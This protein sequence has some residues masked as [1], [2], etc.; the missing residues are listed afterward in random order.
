MEVIVKR[1]SR[2]KVSWF[3]RLF[4][5]SLLL[6]VL[7]MLAAVLLL[8]YLKMEGAPV[9]QVSQTTRLLDANDVIIGE[10]HQGQNRYWVPLE[11]ISEQLLNATLSIEDRKF[12]DHY[13][14]DPT[15]IAGAVVANVK[16]GGKAQ[17]AS[18]ITQQY[19]RNLY[20][21]HDKTWKRKFN[22][23]L[24]ALRLEMYYTKDEI[25]EGYLN[26]IYY[27]HGAYGIEAAARHFFNKK[28]SDLN[29]AEA[30]LLAGI[31]KGP[32]YYSP[33]NDFERAK[34]RQELILRSMVQTGH[35]TSAE[36]EAA[37]NKP[38]ELAISEKEDTGAIGPYFQEYVR[39]L[40]IEEYN[41]DEAL[42]EQGGLQIFTTLDRDM[43]AEAE[44]WVEIE[45]GP[46]EELQA[47]LV[48][49]DPRTGDV[50]AL[51]GGRNYLQSPFNRATQARRSPGSTFKPFLYY[52]ALEHGFTPSSTLLS[53]ATTF[54]FDDGRPDYSPSNFNNNYANDFVTLLQALAFSDNIFAVKTHLFL[55]T[56]TL[57]E[58][59]ARFGINSRLENIPSLALGSNDVQLLE[60]TNS[61]SSFTNGGKR[62]E[63]RFIRKVIDKTGQVIFE[64]EPVTEQILD[65]KLA[66]IMT[67]IMTAMFD[68]SINDYASVTGG[69]VA[70]LVNRPVAGKSGST[71][72]DS[73]MVGYTPQLVTGVWVGYDLEKRLNHATEGQIAKRIWAQF[74]EHALKDD[75]KLDFHK[76][77][78]VTGVYI[79]PKN[80]L[81]ATDECPVKRLTYFVSG[82]EPTEYCQAHMPEEPEVEMTEEEVHE[83]EKFLDRF[84][85][86]FN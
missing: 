55:D 41:I 45:L 79:N 21:T 14:F 74:T 85:K 2:R 34:Q 24:Y 68:R 69:S 28:A 23:A 1:R 31:P 11:E 26:T 13:G 47:A 49:V 40:L 56:E 84:I 64:K 29:L 43:Q 20:L 15:R 38:L 62:V 17:G 8:T 39:N 50:K 52:A 30:S 36:A 67:D 7:S 33:Q 25:L 27:G 76:P 80:G 77:P 3:R 81:L 37:K 53:E 54:T 5:F 58:T 59:A 70:H 42:V 86:W 66:F 4:R 44:R 35:I 78:G 83:K 46:T 61:Y 82:T 32:S 18:T 71:P 19:A 73:W 16:S 57:V 75:L 9:L 6:I 72:F 48:A 51:V 65:P 63:P 60:L 12:Y 10:S 22:E